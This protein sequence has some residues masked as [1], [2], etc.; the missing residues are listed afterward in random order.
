MRIEK[1]LDEGLILSFKIKTTFILSGFISFLDNE[2]TDAKSKNKIN[3]RKSIL[4]QFE[5]NRLT[6]ETQKSFAKYYYN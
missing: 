5:N 2:A 3:D 1:L 4:K 6:N